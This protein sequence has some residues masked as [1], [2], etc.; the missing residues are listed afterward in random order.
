MKFRWQL[1]GYPE[2]FTY[3]WSGYSISGMSAKDIQIM[4]WKVG[5]AW[6]E[7]TYKQHDLGSA[8]T[9]N[10][11]KNRLKY[12]FSSQGERVW[13]EYALTN[14]QFDALQCGK[15]RLVKI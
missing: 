5:R 7:H 1:E 11:M 9:I 6:E 13:I 12:W 8:N 4:Y 2:V 3:P 10:R 15:A 14:D